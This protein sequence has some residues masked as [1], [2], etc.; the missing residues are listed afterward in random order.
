MHLLRFIPADKVPVCGKNRETCKESQPGRNS[1]R[2][3]SMASPPGEKSERNGT[4][5]RAI[6]ERRIQCYNLCTTTITECFLHNGR[7]PRWKPVWERD[8][9]PKSLQNFGDRIYFTVI[10]HIFI[11]KST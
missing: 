8:Q 7:M 10:Y 3:S 6:F 1:F 2:E 9:E 4:V 5:V 11:V